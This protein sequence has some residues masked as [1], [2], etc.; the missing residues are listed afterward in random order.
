MKIKDKH[1]RSIWLHPENEKVVQIIDQRWLPHQF[2]VSNLQTVEDVETAIKEMWVRGAPLIGATAAWGMYLSTFEMPPERNMTDY[3]SG[4]YDRLLNTRPTAV[5][6][7]WAL[8]KMMDAVSDNDHIKETAWYAKTRAQW[9]CD[10]DVETNKK[11][12]EH[13]LKIIEDISIKKNGGTINI[14]THCNAGWLATVDWGTATSPIYHAHDRGI[15]I[16]VWVDETRPRNQGAHITS[17]ELLQQGVLHTLIADNAAGHL[18][19]NGLVDMVIVG[20]DRTSVHGDVC[21][22]IGTYT[23]ALAAYDNHIPFYVAAP[24]SSIDFNMQDAFAEI[25][26]EE[27]HPDEVK[28]VQGLLNGTIQKVLIAPAGTPAKNFA[29]DITP[30]QYITG[31]ITERGICSADKYSILELFPEKKH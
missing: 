19:Q 7:K 30:A 13:G 9:L 12:G 16:H 11:I 26:I 20:T 23:K 28:Y 18:M 8:D 29:F 2:L 25:V 1:F 5:N 24:S 21:N 14:L 4:V 10:A 27:R 3:F 17:W 22:K 31:I 15:N 6:I